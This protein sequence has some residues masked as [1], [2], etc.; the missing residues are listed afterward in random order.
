[1]VDFEKQNRFEEAFQRG[2]QGEI[3]S[4]EAWLQDQGLA[5][6][7][8]SKE[9]VDQYFEEH[10]ENAPNHETQLEDIAE[11]LGFF[12]RRQGQYHLP[13]IGVSGIGKTQLL[14]T[15]QY[16]LD[17]VGISLPTKQ[18]S[19]S[20]FKE[21]NEDGEP[22]WDDVLAEL[23]KLDKA[24]I[25]IDDCGEDK[26]ITHSLQK[27][28][29]S[30]E[31][32]FII[33]TWTPERWN[34]EKEDVNDITPIS[35][36]AELAPLNQKDTEQALQATFDVFSTDSVTLPEELYQRIHEASL[37]IPGLF[38]RLLRETL[39]ETFLKE[40]ELGDAAAVDASTEKLHLV[41]AEE[42]INEISEKKLRILKHILLSRHPKGLRPS[43]LVELLDRDKSTI[44]Y[45][46]HELLSRNIL[47]KEKMGRSTFYR[48]CEPVK[49]ILQLRIERE[50]TFNA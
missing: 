25:L 38:H 20:R 48:V 5:P 8:V 4:Y 18:Y 42:R 50:G 7:R 40:L 47:E 29:Y 34:L 2:Q 31:D 46:L 1:M 3:S 35:K 49:P 12:S 36:E 21:D 10:P 22:Y 44:S 19:A 26:R 11:F 41:N 17:Q 9:F 37:G 23:S 6:D 15:I 39:H 33:T 13:I 27:I 30:V 32:S 43:K 16:M 28:Q 14:H 24:I 45:H